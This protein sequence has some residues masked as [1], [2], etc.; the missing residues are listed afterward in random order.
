MH[1]VFC[2]ESIAAS[3]W[4]PKWKYIFQFPCFFLVSMGISFCWDRF[5]TP[6]VGYSPRH[7]STRVL[8]PERQSAR[9]PERQS[10][11]APERQSARA[12]ERQKTRT[13]EHESARARAQQKALARPHSRHAKNLHPLPKIAISAEQQNVLSSTAPTERQRNSMLKLQSKIRGTIFAFKIRP[14]QRPSPHLNRKC[15]AILRGI[16]FWV[17]S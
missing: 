16:F 9:A 4:H 11:R 2:G 6:L 17:A 10:A 13:P 15:A 14:R 3:A 7:P 5:K 12:P 1:S 8:P